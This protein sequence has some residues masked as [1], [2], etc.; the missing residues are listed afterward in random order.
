MVGEQRGR[1]RDGD[2]GGSREQGIIGGG[3]KT[4]RGFSDLTSS[5]TSS[6]P[7]LIFLI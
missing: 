7:T 1:T 2:E 6:T 5:P 4:V 3:L